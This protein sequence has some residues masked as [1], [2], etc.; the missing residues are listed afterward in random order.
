MATRSFL[1][2]FFLYSLTLSHMELGKKEEEVFIPL[3][4]LV[5]DG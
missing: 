2:Y 4:F 3:S 1:F 5:L